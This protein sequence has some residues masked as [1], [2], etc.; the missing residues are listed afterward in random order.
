M[1]EHKLLNKLNL[2]IEELEKKRSQEREGSIAWEMLGARI[3]ELREAYIDVC[4]WAIDERIGNMTL[5][6]D[7]FMNEP[8]NK[9]EEEGENAWEELFYQL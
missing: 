4:D 7:S 9:K 1:N 6:C 5:A 8:E 2:K 3:L